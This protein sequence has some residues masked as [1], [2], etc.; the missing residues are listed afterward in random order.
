[1]KHVPSLSL[2]AADTAALDY[3]KSLHAALNG[4]RLDEGEGDG[5]EGDGGDGDDE[6]GDDGDDGDGDLDPEVVKWK[7]LARKHEERSK[8][9]LAA[10]K[11]AER[12]RDDARQAS[13]SDQEKA[14]EDAKAAARAEAMADLGGRLVEAAVTKAA[15]G[16][17]SDDQVDGL[18]EGLDPVRFL[19]EDG[20]VDADKVKAFVDR[21][22]PDTGGEN[23][24]GRRAPGLGQGRRPGSAKKS[25]KDRGLEEARRRFGES[26]KT[27]H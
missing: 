2:R 15:A 6:D 13:M 19:D 7:R 22:A 4:I 23:G 25:G 1:M 21:I 20:D 10:R 18:L 9:N 5:D 11:K 26:V 12:E 14:V 3:A 16:R 17:L 8:A 27:N 24:N